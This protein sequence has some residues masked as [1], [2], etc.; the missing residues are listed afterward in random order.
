MPFER[1]DINC[2]KCEMVELSCFFVYFIAVYLFFIHFKDDELPLY[3][4]LFSTHTVFGDVVPQK[5][6]LIPSKEFPSLLL[7]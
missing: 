3:K 1:H 5:Y 4:Q 6:I 7:F 2:D